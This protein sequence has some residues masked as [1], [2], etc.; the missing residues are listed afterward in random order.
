MKATLFS[1]KTQVV[2]WILLVPGL[3]FGIYFIFS[4]N[5]LKLAEVPVI[6]IL[7]TPEFNIGNGNPEPGF[8]LI[9]YG[10]SE[11]A[12]ELIGLLILIG[13]FLVAFSKEREEDEYFIKLRFDAMLFAI[14]VNVAIQF[15]AFIFLYDFVFLTFM[16]TNL[17]MVLLLY[18]IRFKYSLYKLR[19]VGSDDQ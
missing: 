11:I 5:E 6:S 13:A 1:P 3:L 15:L 17:F 12:D 19:N 16:M 10:K 18:I 7:G 8:G 9:R 4:G 14:Y 2:G